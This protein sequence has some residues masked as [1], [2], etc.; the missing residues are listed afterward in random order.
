MGGRRSS[1]LFLPSGRPPVAFGQA[2]SALARYATTRSRTTKRCAVMAVDGALCAVTCVAS[3]FLR[4]G[5]LP[6]RDTPYALLIAVS[7]VLAVP[8]FWALGLYRELY[9]QFGMRGMAG[10]N[11]A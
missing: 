1:V 3:I 8:M 5:F 11:W 10:A 7:V 6:E 9:S 2:M 4:I